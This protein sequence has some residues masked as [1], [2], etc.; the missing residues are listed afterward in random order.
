MAEFLKVKKA[1]LPLAFLT[2][3]FC[4]HFQSGTSTGA[5]LNTRAGV[6]VAYVSMYDNVEFIIND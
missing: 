1:F 4:Y 2:K 6:C 5:W 3:A